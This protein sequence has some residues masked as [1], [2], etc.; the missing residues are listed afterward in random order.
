MIRLRATFI[1]GLSVFLLAWASTAGATGLTLQWDPSTDSSV[2]GY[3]LSWGT[4]AGVHP[5]TVDV[6]SQTSWTVPALA[7]GTTYY[8]VVQAYNAS[9]QMSAN[10]NEA[11]GPT[12]SSGTGCVGAGCSSGPDFNG[13]TRP[14]LVWQNDT[15]RQVTS[16]YMSG[17]Q[18]NVMQGWS[19]L[20]SAGVAG[21]RVVALRDFNGDG[22]PDVV[23]QND[24]TRQVTVWYMTGANGDVM[25]GWNY[26]SQAGV[27][28]WTVVGTGDFNGDGKPDLVWEND[29]TRQVTVWY[30]SGTQGNVLQGWNYLS[31]AGVPGWTVV[32]TGDFNSDGKPD[33]IWLNDATRQVTVWYMGGA[34]G[35]VQEGWNYLSSAGV[36]GWTV[37][38][39][40]D[41]NGDGK[42]DLVWM[43]D[44]TRQ[45]TVW[46]MSGAQGNV[47]Q[48]WNYLS[49]AGVPGWKVTVR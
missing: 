27:P 24:A 43:N 45:V 12:V 11:S 41:F 33:L 9:G 49:S 40:G 13:D 8:F 20:S 6:H 18:G 28:G 16:W 37:A 46:Y 15:T 3:V 44:S 38:G 23:W 30:M 35:Y 42:P 5:N 14:D 39:T 47:M 26:L 31:S 25:Q 1:G 22:K 10:S 21:W 34:G 36:A 19:W 48:S 2:T 7:N 32:G 29:T 4:Q 17:A